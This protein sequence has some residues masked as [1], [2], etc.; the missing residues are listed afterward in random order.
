M[1][2]RAK[3]TLLTLAPLLLGACGGTQKPGTEEQP[4]SSSERAYRAQYSRLAA[5]VKEGLAS[6]E[7]R[8][9]GTCGELS[10][11]NCRIEADGPG[12]YVNTAS[13]EVLE[14]CGGACMMGPREDMCVACP[15][16]EWTCG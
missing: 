4:L 16:P 14:V 7:C 11:I 6:G 3:W 1:L 8:V 12:Y 2:Q 10:F 13:G 15:P 5:E 9:D